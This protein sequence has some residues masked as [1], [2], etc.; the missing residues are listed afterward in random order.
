MEDIMKVAA[1]VYQKIAAD[2]AAKIVDNRY[3][4]GEKIY[5]RSYLA[6]QYKVSSETARRAICVLSDLE[7]VDV[8]KGSGVVIKSYDNAVKFVH[9]YNDIQSLNDLKKDILSSIERQKKET[10]FL[11]KSV[12][13]I[14]DRTERF[15]SINPFIPFEVEI[16]G[17]TPLLNKSLSELNF[18]HHTAATIIA[19]KRDNTLMMSPGPYAILQKHDVLYYCGEDNCQDRVKSFLYPDD[20]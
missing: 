16:T 12:S 19:I 4:V 1:P 17:K 15:Q 6:S 2:I 18:W 3:R 9:Q 10:K 14:I 8:T 7:I 5:A 11:L 13:S 20:E